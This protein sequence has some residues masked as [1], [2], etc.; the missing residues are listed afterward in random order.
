MN[1]PHLFDLV[2][3]VVRGVTP[4]GKIQLVVEDILVLARVMV[5]QKKSNLEQQ[6]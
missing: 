5:P 1:Y 3:Q 4:E 6:K 2:G